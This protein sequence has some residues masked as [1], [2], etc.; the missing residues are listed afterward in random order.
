MKPGKIKKQ[1]ETK[2]E[3][4]MNG[5]NKNQYFCFH[6]NTPLPIALWPSG[7]STL[8]VVHCLGFNPRN[9]SIKERIEKNN[10][11]PLAKF[12]DFMQYNKHFLN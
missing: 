11:P 12:Y 10:T 8:V 7:M 9:F 3:A 4:C 2:N 1:L 6:S 5:N